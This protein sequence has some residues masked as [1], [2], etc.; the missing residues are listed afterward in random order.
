MI[1]VL[2]F[3]YLILIKNSIIRRFSEKLMALSDWKKFLAESL[4]TV[5]V[6]GLQKTYKNAG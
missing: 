6:K 3:S 5:L 2:N 4:I 1:L